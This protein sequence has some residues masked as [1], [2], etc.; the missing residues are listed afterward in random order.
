[1]RQRV[2]HLR[3]GS[4]EVSAIRSAL[5]LSM[6]RRQAHLAHVRMWGGKKNTVW[7]CFGRSLRALLCTTANQH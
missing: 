6:R 7:N 4:Y 3:V 1:M 5:K 2:E